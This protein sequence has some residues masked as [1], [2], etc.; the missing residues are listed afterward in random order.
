MTLRNGKLPLFKF[1][2]GNSYE[3]VWL[4]GKQ[5]G[6][7]IYTWADG[8]RYEGDWRDDNQH[9]RGIKTWPDGAR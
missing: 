5:H 6:H 8:D 4:N 9:G 3:G 1:D 2:D 7:G